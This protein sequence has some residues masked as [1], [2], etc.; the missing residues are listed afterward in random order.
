MLHE[1]GLHQPAE[2]YS[3]PH[4]PMP[5]EQQRSLPDHQA[6]PC[7]LLNHSWQCLI[8]LRYEAEIPI[9]TLTHAYPSSL[10]DLQILFQAIRLSEAPHQRSKLVK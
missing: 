9:R 5:S 1:P 8:H 4:R 10:I 7:L 6:L 2:P 3:D